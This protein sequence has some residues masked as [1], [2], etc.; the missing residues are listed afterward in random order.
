MALQSLSDK[1]PNPP[2][3]LLARAVTA[4]PPSLPLRL[5]LP[6][7]SACD[8]LSLPLFLCH[9]PSFCESLTHSSVSSGMLYMGAPPLRS[10]QSLDSAISEVSNVQQNPPTDH[11]HPAGRLLSSRSQVSSKGIALHLGA[12]DSRRGWTGGMSSLMKVCTPGMENHTPACGCSEPVF[13]LLEAFLRECEVTAHSWRV[14]G[15]H[16]LPFS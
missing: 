2:H 5:L 7:S 11:C 9:Y 13:S 3:G 4:F 16:T 8:A 12:S 15:W 14:R 1:V 10:S 6:S